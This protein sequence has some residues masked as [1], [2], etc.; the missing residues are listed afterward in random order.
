ML[1]KVACVSKGFES[2]SCS[3]QPLLPSS[4]H[5]TTSS[6][7]TSVMWESSTTCPL[8]LGG[9]EKLGDYSN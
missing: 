3:E 8:Q 1:M 7:S 2:S 5:W 6:P 4:V 9:G